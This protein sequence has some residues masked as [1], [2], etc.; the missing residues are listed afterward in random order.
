MPALAALGFRV[1]APDLRGFGDSDTP[2][3]VAEY[4]IKKSCDDL[5]RIVDHFQQ[6]YAVVVGHDWYNGP[7]RRLWTRRRGWVG[8]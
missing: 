3:D 2:A 6:P 1:V 5:A 7:G 8:H 4:T